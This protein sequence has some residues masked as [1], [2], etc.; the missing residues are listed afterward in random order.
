[1][2][3]PIREKPTK[4]AKRMSNIIH[5]VLGIFLSYLSQHSTGAVNDNEQALTGH[6]PNL[7]TDYTSLNFMTAHTILARLYSHTE[8]M[9]W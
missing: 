7:T 6:I 1:M 4:P 8:N 2:E 5:K 9:P 3:L